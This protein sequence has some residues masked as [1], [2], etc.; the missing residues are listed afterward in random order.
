MHSGDSSKTRIV[1]LSAANTG[2]DPKQTTERPTARFKY[3]SF[4]SS[5]DSSRESETIARHSTGVTGARAFAERNVHR[6]WIPSRIKRE[7]G[8]ERG[9]DEAEKQSNGRNNS[10]RLSKVKRPVRTC[11]IG[12]SYFMVLRASSLSAMSSRRGLRALNN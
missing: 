10:R 2:I 1:Y 12:K 11:V 8:G 6:F 3:R 4:E 7:R 5:F 9:R